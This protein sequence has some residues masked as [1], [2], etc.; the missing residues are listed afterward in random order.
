MYIH[1]QTTVKD[2][3]PRTAT[4]SAQCVVTDARLS[5]AVLGLLVIHAHAV[6][7]TCARSLARTARDA[8]VAPR[9]PVTDRAVLVWSIYHVC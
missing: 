6:S 8:A 1:Q 7:D 3:I 5:V 4:T 9:G 2:N